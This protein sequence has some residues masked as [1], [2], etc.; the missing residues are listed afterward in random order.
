[1]DFGIIPEKLNTVLTVVKTSVSTKEKSLYREFR[2]MG[3]SQIDSAF[4]SIYI[5]ACESNAK[6]RRLLEKISR[7]LSRISSTATG[8]IKRDKVGLFSDSSLE[9][10]TKALSFLKKKA[11]VVVAAVLAVVLCSMISA[12]NSKIPSLEVYVNG[13]SIG[14]VES[15]EKLDEVLE[16]VEQRV[17]DITGEC[18]DLPCTITYSLNSSTSSVLAD[19]ELYTILNSYTQDE[20]CN[21]YGLYIDNREV[22]VLRNRQDITFVISTLEAQHLALTGENAHIANRVTVKYEEYASD[23]VISRT[24][25]MNLLKSVEPEESETRLLSSAGEDAVIT[26]VPDTN[27]ANNL[28][29]SIAQSLSSTGQS[30]VVITYE[31]VNLETKREYIDYPIRYLED[32]SLY[33]GQTKISTYGRR[34]LADVTYSVSSVDG[35]EISRVQNSINY[36]YEPV[37]QVVKVGTKALPETYSEEIT[38]G[39]YMIY[40]LASFKQSDKYGPRYLN[41]RYDFHYGFDM[42]ANYGTPIYAAASGEVILAGY[43]GSF[44]YCVKIKHADGAITL[45]AHCS[46]LLV[47]EGDTVTQGQLIAEVGNT[48]YSFGNHCHF[49]VIVDGARVDPEDYIYIE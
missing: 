9:I 45:Y 23:K 20:T 26:E 7:P 35:E 41:G 5:K 6:T 29:D 19:D 46:D 28:S 40:P 14:C 3:L 30:T 31:S 36:I 42:A 10:V 49:E 11:S 39:K 13:V 8:H 44:G 24:Q 25:L 4:S 18:Y 32:T 47:S 17:T 33:Q 21:A 22:A 12:N 48:G 43:N 2:D 38:D 27:G 15:A 1:M 37:T 16:R 34:G